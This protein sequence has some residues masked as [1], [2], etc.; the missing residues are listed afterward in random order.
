MKKPQLGTALLLA[1]E[2]SELAAAL[3]RDA[4]GKKRSEVKVVGVAISN[5]ELE[6]VQLLG[7]LFLHVRTLRADRIRAISRYYV[8]DQVRRGH[9]LAESLFTTRVLEE[10]NR[11][12]T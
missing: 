4:Q 6:L 8:H 9:D 2:A 7:A 11:G 12:L 3:L 5:T 10:L 1:E